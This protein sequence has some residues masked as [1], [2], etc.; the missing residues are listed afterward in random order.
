MSGGLTYTTNYNAQS[1]VS[2][3]AG[4]QPMWLTTNTNHWI[5]DATRPNGIFAS[6]TLDFGNIDHPLGIN[7]NLGTT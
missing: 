1:L 3:P 2:V 5:G 4:Q 6:Y 7:L